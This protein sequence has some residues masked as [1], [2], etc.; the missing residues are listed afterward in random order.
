VSTGAGPVTIY[1]PLTPPTYTAPTPS[2]G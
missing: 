2:W 1:E